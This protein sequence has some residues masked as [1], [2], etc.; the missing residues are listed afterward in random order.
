MVKVTFPIKISCSVT[1]RYFARDVQ[2]TCI[3]RCREFR[4]FHELYTTV[5]T[6]Q[7]AIKRAK[8]H[9]PLSIIVKVSLID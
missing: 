1:K 9:L 8:L 5:S 7:S 6:S 4:Y 2:N 3:L